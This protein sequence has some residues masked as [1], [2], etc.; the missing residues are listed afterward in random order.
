MNHTTIECGAAR[1]LG[2]LL[3]TTMLTAACATVASAQEGTA[4][5]TIRV[6]SERSGPGGDGDA[7]PPGGGAD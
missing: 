2:L 1:I 6:E 3:A 5:P 4:L 7:T